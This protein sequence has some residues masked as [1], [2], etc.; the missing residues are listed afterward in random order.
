MVVMTWPPWLAVNPE[1]WQC[2]EFTKN[3]NRRPGV[4]IEVCVVQQG[5]CSFGI[6]TDDCTAHR[7][8][9]NSGCHILD[10]HLQT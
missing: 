5:R 7:I 8:G 2:N 1:C 6:F 4:F 3:L 9:F 10:R